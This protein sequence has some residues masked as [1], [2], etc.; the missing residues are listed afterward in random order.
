ME[1]CDGNFVLV[2]GGAGYLGSVLVRQLL[3]SGYHVRVLDNLIYGNLFSLEELLGNSKFE[4]VRGDVS[5]EQDLRGA[6][7]DAKCVFHLAALVGEPVCQKN[8]ALCNSTNYI[9]TL[10]LARFCI[11][12]SNVERL[13]C[14][15]TC[16]CYG[17]SGEKWVN[18]ESETN[19]IGIYGTTKLMAEKG[20]LKMSREGLSICILRLPTLYGL[21]PRMRF[22]LVVNFFVKKALTKK[23]IT[24]FG[25]NQWRPFLHVID[26]SRAFQLCMEAPLAKIKN[27]LFCVGDNK[28][29]YTIMQIANL[30]ATQIQG[31]Q[32]IVDKNK[33]DA[34]SYRVDFSKIHQKLGFKTK[35]QVEHGIKEICDSIISGKLT[36]LDNV[37]YYNAQRLGKPEGREERL[38]SKIM[39]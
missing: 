24:V 38:V 6:L 20:L 27:E 12:N 4:F 25:G 26:A 8:K 13:I 3:A 1:F 9:S 16:S 29:N 7:N 19:P 17:N 32:I 2:T 37:K 39:E 10:R 28:E 35:M 31:I 15:S 18:E 23:R 34:L 11:K 30:V 5:N 33:T 21:S 22:D 14:T 36:D